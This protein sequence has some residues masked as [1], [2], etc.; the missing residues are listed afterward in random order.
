M[1]PKVSVIMSAFNAEKSIGKSVQSILDQTFEDFEFLI[2]DDC[3]TD[4]TSK[5]LNRFSDERIKLYKNKENIGLTKSLNFLI[6]NS[7]T[8]F[9]VRQD[10][11]DY[12]H[13]RRI[14]EQYKILID[15]N[16]DFCVTRAQN[17]QNLKKIPG[18]SYFLPYKAILKYKNPFIHGT[19]MIQKK[20]L[21]QIGMYDEEF[22]YAQDYKLFSDLIKSGAKG[23]KIYKVLYYLN[24]KNNISSNFKFEQRKYANLVRRNFNS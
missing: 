1:S 5:I 23:K 13:K 15:Q 2:V 9:I 21:L 17:I 8:K 6:N 7:K 20:V 16:I 11:D 4:I 18:L 24:T 22:V 12:S 3:S 19:L 10:A 14:E